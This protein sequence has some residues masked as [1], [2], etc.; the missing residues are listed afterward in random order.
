MGLKLQF[1]MV[2]IEA[3]E[4]SAGWMQHWRFYS[5]EKLKLILIIH[6]KFSS[7]VGEFGEKWWAE[8]W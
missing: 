6:N 1:V 4:L 3:I 2:L 8:S 5:V 7:F